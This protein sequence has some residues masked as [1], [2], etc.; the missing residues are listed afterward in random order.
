MNRLFGNTIHLVRAVVFVLIQVI[1]FNKLTLFDVARPFPYVLVILFLPIRFTRWQGLLAAEELTGLAVWGHVGLAD[2]A[3]ITR[4]TKLKSLLLGFAH[5]DKVQKLRI[6]AHQYGSSLV[7]GH[8]CADLTDSSI[9]PLN[10]IVISQN[11]FL[12]LPL[13]HDY[14]RENQTC[15]NTWS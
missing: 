6:L 1:L 4:F 2:P 3:D 9:E 12:K 10:L 11:M 8:G 5:T 14:H 7:A 13:Y 15:L